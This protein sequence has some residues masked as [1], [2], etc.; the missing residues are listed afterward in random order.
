MV[1]KDMHVRENLAMDNRN[2]TFTTRR[3]CMLSFT[4]LILIGAFFICTLVAVSFI[5]YNFASCAHLVQDSDDIV[6]TPHKP[7]LQP[8]Q[9]RTSDHDDDDDAT[10]EKVLDKD[11]R[12]PRSVVPEKYNISLIPHLSNNT[13]KFEGE[14]QIIVRVVEDCQNITM[15]VTELRIAQ[16]DVS[17][18]KLNDNGG[19]L[20]AGRG[21]V[22]SLRIRKQYFVEAKQFFVIEFY[23]KLQKDTHYE[24]RIKFYGDIL[25]YLQGF[26]RSSHQV[27]NETRWLAST[28]FQPTDARRAFPCFDE[29]ALKATFTLNIARPMNLSSISNM[30]KKEGPLRKVDDLPGYV[31]DNYME[32]LP[33]STYLVAYTVS[34]FAN[35]TKGSFSVWARPDAIQSAQYALIVG[36]K[37]LKFLEQYFDIPYPLPKVDMIALPDFH[38]GAMENWGLIT[39]RE[40]AMLYEEG[41]SPTTNKQRIA[42]VVGHELAHQ[43]FGNLVT[44]TWWTDIW[45]NEGFA[46][47]MEY[48]TVDA[49]EPQWRTMDQFVVTEL[50]NVFHLD[51]FSSSHKISI[52]VANPDEIN[53]IFDKISYAKG[54]TII[55]M[56][57]H[58]LT[59]KVFRSGLTKYLRE[60]AYSA[61]EQDDLWR[62]LTN[63]AKENGLLSNSTS[64][65]EIMDTWT[66]QM[67]F[68]VLIV[69][70]K[71]NSFVMQLE[72]KKF[73]YVNESTSEEANSLWWIP[74]TYTTSKELNFE[75]TRPITWVPK[76]RDFAINS[77]NLSTADWYIFNIQQTGYYRVNYDAENWAAITK[78]LLQ[79]SKFKEIA[80]SN[81]AQLIDDA[82]NLARA[83]LISYDVALNLTTYLAHE[84]DHVPWKAAIVAF[85]FID[86]M[87]V[88][89]GDY[90]LLKTYLLKLLNKVY[91]Q[92]G[93]TDEADETDMLMLWKRNEILNMACHLG[94]QKCITD[95]SRHFQNWIQ[96]PNPDLNNPISPNLRNIVYCTAIQYGTEAEWNFAFDRYMNSK[97]SSEQEVLLS[98]LG[99]SKEPWILSRYLRRAISG[100][101]IRKQDVYR[102]FAAVSHNV[103]G[104]QIAFD[105]IRNHWDKIITYLGKSM[106]NLNMIIKFPTKLMNTRFLL[107]D[108]KSFVKND[109]KEA[110]RTVQQAVE[111]VQINVDWMD[112][113][114]NT[115]VEWL[116]QQEINK[117]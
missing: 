71:P 98:A 21:S 3:G 100:D 16:E 104:Q 57:S 32:S 108:L 13:F 99:C 80:P 97:V 35:L 79:P 58:F 63:E 56:M 30:P 102:V 51:A 96:D 117:S 110:G 106:S 43:W 15:H 50:Q 70:K 84:E 62:F 18:R 112:R 31:W 49:I 12:L 114:Y 82:M 66:L 39:F 41:V 55:R 14:V 95:C 107:A 86:S 75:N 8:G 4:T 17:V 73:V 5:I 74:I 48:L 59:S 33:M 87:F 109:L 92:V 64:V 105:Y 61:A 60:M 67:G 52:E 83:G 93:F 9:E 28:Q 37:I 19:M 69:R 25:D 47:Y 53:E 2:T 34:D 85:N 88:K 45:L 81:R 23:E 22:D 29:P 42:S 94:H 72:Q 6:C 76:T 7:H 65:K 10:E 46:S 115:I 40:I 38:A 26:Y 68:P 11:V 116:K 44:P 77:K 89:E 101:G 78:H 113:N 36:P 24:I 20:G 90:H 54:A 1:L 111:Q 91:D 27:G 103:V